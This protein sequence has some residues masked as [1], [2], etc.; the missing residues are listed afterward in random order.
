MSVLP[1]LG[2]KQLVGL[3][4][5]VGELQRLTVSAWRSTLRR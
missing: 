3:A 5:V 2:T 1:C 4:D